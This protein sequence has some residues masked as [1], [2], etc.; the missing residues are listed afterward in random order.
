MNIWMNFQKLHISSDAKYMN[1]NNEILLDI[2]YYRITC[3]FIG[4][5][6]TFKFFE[7]YLN[8]KGFHHIF[9]KELIHSTKKT[10]NLYS[11]PIHY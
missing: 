5:I 10:L 9:I 7:I 11:R 6:N 4:N 2:K 1:Q 3:P 8:I